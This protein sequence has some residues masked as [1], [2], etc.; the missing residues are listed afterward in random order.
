MKSLKVIIHV[1]EKEKIK[2]AYNNIHNLLKEVEDVEVVLLLNSAVVKESVNNK[3][4]EKLL[5]IN[6]NV[7]V[8]N[9]S[10]KANKIDKSEL[11]DGIN[12]V[13]AGILELVKR[14]AAGFAYVRP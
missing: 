13:A 12:V 7:S 9:N 14:Q 1:S 3:L 4:L 8:C 5:K 10:L 2:A 6:V 11:L